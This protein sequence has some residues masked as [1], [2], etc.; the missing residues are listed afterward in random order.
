MTFLH[1]LYLNYQLT[2]RPLLS[3]SWIIQFF[4]TSYWHIK[5]GSSLSVPHQNIYPSQST[6]INTFVVVVVVVLYQNKTFL[7]TSLL[8][9]LQGLHVVL[10]RY[11]QILELPYRI[12]NGKVFALPVLCFIIF[13]TLIFLF[14]AFN[15]DLSSTLC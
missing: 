12:L 3:S 5:T 11:S 6:H 2:P 1:K 15:L 8:K 7:L 9:I 14:S 13:G 4:L 10:R